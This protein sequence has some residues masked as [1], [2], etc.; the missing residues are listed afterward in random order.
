MRSGQLRHVGAIKFDGGTG[1]R[2]GFG[3]KPRAPVTVVANERFSIEPLSGAEL[4]RAQQAQ[5]DVTH[6]VKMR[7]RPGIT[8]QHW[9]EYPDALTAGVVTLGIISVLNVRGRGREL[10]LMCRERV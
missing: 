8:T 4:I 10:E 6:R 5:S 3:S 9:I 1:T 2:D 7:F